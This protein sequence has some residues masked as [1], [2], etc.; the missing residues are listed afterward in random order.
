MSIY[1][2]LQ[3]HGMGPKEV[4]LLTKAYERTLHTLCVQGSRRSP[5]G[6]DRED[7]N[8]YRANRHQRP[9][10]DFGSG[11]QRTGNPVRPAETF[12]A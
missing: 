2:H 7:D 12:L 5:N 1:L 8:Q 6:N 10:K 11:D 4:S 9:R 3:T